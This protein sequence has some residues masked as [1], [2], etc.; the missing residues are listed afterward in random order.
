MRAARP[1]GACARRPLPDRPCRAFTSCPEGEAA[2]LLDAVL[3]HT[4]RVLVRAYPH[5][6]L[7]TAGESPFREPPEVYVVEDFVFLI[8][9]IRDTIGRFHD[10]YRPKQRPDDGAPA[11]GSARAAP[12]TIR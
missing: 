4:E 8:M 2:I 3:D 7:P 11:R 12:P 1:R 6:A 5:L 9:A 10:T